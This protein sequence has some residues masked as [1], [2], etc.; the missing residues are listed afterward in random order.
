MQLIRERH[1]TKEPVSCAWARGAQVPAK[2]T[3]I[4][5]SHRP[6]TVAANLEPEVAMVMWSCK[7]TSRMVM[8]SRIKSTLMSLRSCVELEMSC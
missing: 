5:N 2:V 4:T 7:K 3:A 6:G 8:Q 1:I